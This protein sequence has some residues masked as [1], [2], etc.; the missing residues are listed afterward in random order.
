MFFILIYKLSISFTKKILNVFE[1]RRKLSVK[2]HELPEPYTM[3]N[4]N[5][6]FITLLLITD[7]DS[8]CKIPKL[9]FLTCQSILENLWLRY[10]MT[11]TTR[12][13]IKVQWRLFRIAFYIKIPILAGTGPCSAYARCSFVSNEG[14]FNVLSSCGLFKKWRAWLCF[15]PL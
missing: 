12:K 2:K 10:K 9:L 11:S 8:A 5:F 4:F 15:K 14:A 6:P 13:S 1:T 3:L 7:Y